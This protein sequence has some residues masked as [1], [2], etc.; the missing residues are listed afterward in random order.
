V[1]LNCYPRGQVVTFLHKAK[2]EIRKKKD[3]KIKTQAYLSGP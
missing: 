1:S 3:K 2:N